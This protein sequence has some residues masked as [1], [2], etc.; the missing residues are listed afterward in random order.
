MTLEIQLQLYQ[1]P[2]QHNVYMVLFER[3]D[4]RGVTLVASRPAR[5]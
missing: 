4:V 2:L 1:L 5:D 3:D